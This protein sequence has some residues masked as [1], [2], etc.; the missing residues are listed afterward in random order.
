MPWPRGSLSPFVTCLPTEPLSTPGCYHIQSY[1]RL[2]IK[3]KAADLMLK[4]NPKFVLR[5][6][7]A[8]QAIAQP[9]AGDFSELATLQRR[10]SALSTSTRP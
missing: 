5:N 3:R 10:W 4:S 2:R 8:E 7:L 1:L 9:K 6:H